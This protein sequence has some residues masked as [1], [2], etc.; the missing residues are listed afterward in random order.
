[1]KL[2]CAGPL[3]NPAERG[4]LSELAGRFRAAGLE[5]FVPHEHE[6]G[7]LSADA[8]FR[9]DYRELSTANALF[10]WLVRRR[11][12]TRAGCTGAG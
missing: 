2:Y 10:A 6:L 5:C 1:M 11:A 4:F 7:E 8:V 3:F 12:T 9:L